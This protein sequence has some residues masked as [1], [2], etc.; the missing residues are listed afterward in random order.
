MAWEYLK[1]E[2]F[3]IRYKIVAEHLP[4]LSDKTV[5]D[6]NCGEPAFRKFIKCKK[7]YAND[8][9]KPDNIDGVEFIQKKDDEIDI[10]TDIIVL[11][12]YGGGELTGQPLESK[13]A[14]ETLIKLSK[15]KPEY[16]VVEM[17]QKWEDDFKIM[18]SLK[19]LLTDYSVHFERRIDIEPVEH[20]HNRRFVTIFK[21]EG[22][23][24]S[25]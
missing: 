25:A 16:I 14:S 8:I 21:Y 1:T 22:I 6:L 3:D 7:Y 13:T 19:K 2:P 17:V 20:Y 24:T 18:S 5:L 15:Y 10:K 12:G 4:D 11:F 23:S 9:F